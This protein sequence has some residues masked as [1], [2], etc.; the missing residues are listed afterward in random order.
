MMFKNCML[1]LACHNKEKN[2][3]NTIDK[4]YN[5]QNFL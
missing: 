1:N 5:D 3:I 2:P 4:Y